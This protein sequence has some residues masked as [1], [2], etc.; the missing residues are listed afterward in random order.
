MLADAVQIFDS[1]EVAA[2]FLGAPFM[3][4]NPATSRLN[5]HRRKPNFKI[6]PW[7]Y[8]GYL[9]DIQVDNT[10][11]FTGLWTGCGFIVPEPKPAPEPHRQDCWKAPPSDDRS[12]ERSVT[13]MGFALAVFEANKHH[14]NGLPNHQPR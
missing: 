8:A 1:I 4:E 9:E 5:T 2:T 3:I 13:P 6:H 10:M 12:D 7:Q 11:K 14:I